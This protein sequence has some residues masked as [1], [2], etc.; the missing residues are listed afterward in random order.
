M[1]FIYTSIVYNSDYDTKYYMTM[2]RKWKRE[3]NAD[4]L[5]T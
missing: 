4:Q 3:D 5:K 1:D 2:D